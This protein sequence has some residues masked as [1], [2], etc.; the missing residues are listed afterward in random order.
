MHGTIDIAAFVGHA[1]LTYRGHDNQPD[2]GTTP[3][4]PIK[5]LDGRSRTLDF[6]LRGAVAIPTDADFKIELSNGLHRWVTKKAQVTPSAPGEATI[7]VLLDT[8]CP[9]R[10]LL[11]W[12]QGPYD[13]K[14][15]YELASESQNAPPATTRFELNDEGGSAR[16][17]C[18]WLL[19]ALIILIEIIGW[20]GFM[21]FAFRFDKA[22]ISV[23]APNS[24]PD[25]RR[26][27]PDRSTYLRAALWFPR[28]FVTG[29]RNARIREEQTREGLRLI[30]RPGGVDALPSGTSWPS[31]QLESV[32]QMLE[33]ECPIEVGQRPSPVTLAWGSILVNRQQRRRLGLWEKKRFPTARQQRF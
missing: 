13:V 5:D 28:L 3:T 23:E 2:D 7:R 6:V 19:V 29:L 32:G 25:L 21:A 33:Q 4:L 1:K 18:L 14:L 12:W 20:I 10:C 8:W 11:G 30:A 27:R 31:L 24:I 26:L 22:V 16:M 9:Y 15:T 17:A